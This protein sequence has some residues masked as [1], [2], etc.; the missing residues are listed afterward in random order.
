MKIKVGDLIKLDNSKKT[1]DEG[2]YNKFKNFTFRATKVEYSGDREYINWILPDN[3]KTFR[4]GEIMSFTTRS[5]TL[6][7]FKLPDKL[8]RM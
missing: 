3:H 7:S 4:K 8:F 5:I 1:I 6:V 2:F